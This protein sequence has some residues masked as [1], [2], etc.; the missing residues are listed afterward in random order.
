MVFQGKI[1]PQVSPTEILY[2]HRLLR[3][4]KILVQIVNKIRFVITNTVLC[5][6]TLCI[7][8]CP[9]PSIAKFNAVFFQMIG[10]IIRH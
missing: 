1:L 2:E 5:S 8:T 7:R 10:Y 6:V 3:R 9:K 4:K